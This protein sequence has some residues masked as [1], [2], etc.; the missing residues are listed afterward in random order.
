MVM[1]MNKRVMIVLEQ[2]LQSKGI[3]RYEL[4]KRSDIGYQTVDN[5]YKN[6]VVRY[7]SDLLLRM[8]LALDCEVGDIVKIVDV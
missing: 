2:F 7:D 4:S 1:D 6:K 5:Y 8:C 3:T